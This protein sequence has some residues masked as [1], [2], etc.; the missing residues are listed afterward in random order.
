MN[1]KP[2]KKALGRAVKPTIMPDLTKRFTSIQ[3]AKAIMAKRTAMKLSLIDVSKALS[4]SK[5]TLIKIEKGQT[6]VSFANILK[7]LE[8]LGLS[9]TII[10]DDINHYNDFTGKT[11]DPWY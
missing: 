8:L 9:F 10:S 7:V 5:P 6:N 4:I 2:I 11:D 1:N 3:L